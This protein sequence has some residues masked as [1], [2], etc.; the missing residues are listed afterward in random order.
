VCRTDD[1]AASATPGAGFILRVRSFGGMA[2][3]SGALAATQTECPSR[4]FNEFV[5]HSPATFFPI[6]IRG[7]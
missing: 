1:A 3:K 7:P 5:N 4:R 6:A 2:G